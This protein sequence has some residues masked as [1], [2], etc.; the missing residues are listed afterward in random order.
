LLSE[1]GTELRIP[2]LL[3]NKR[4]FFA[5]GMTHPILLRFGRVHIRLDA[6]QRLKGL[7]NLRFLRHLENII[8][9]GIFLHMLNSLLV[10]KGLVEG[11]LFGA[12]VV[13]VVQEAV[14]VGERVVEVLLLSRLDH[15][16]VLRNVLFLALRSCDYRAFLYW[17]WRGLEGQRVVGGFGLLFRV[18]EV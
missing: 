11:P 13:L 3:L 2:G 5:T 14:R 10:G 16:F 18:V 7:D 6:S 17:R 12:V 1:T 9:E 4:W 8:L 15:L